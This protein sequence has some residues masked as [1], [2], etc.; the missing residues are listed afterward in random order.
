MKHMKL[1]DF[2]F[3]TILIS[4]TDQVYHLAI[5]VSLSFNIICSYSIISS[6]FSYIFEILSCLFFLSSDL[7]I[8]YPL[9]FLNILKCKPHRVSFHFQ[10]S[11]WLPSGLPTGYLF[12]FSSCSNSPGLLYPKHIAIIHGAQG[13]LWCHLAHAFVLAIPFSW[14]TFLSL[15][16]LHQFQLLCLV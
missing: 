15:E 13:V 5:L 11:K 6:S 9:H 14:D 2:L 8:T 4:I 10:N 16:L 3:L 1:N 12:S 7:Q